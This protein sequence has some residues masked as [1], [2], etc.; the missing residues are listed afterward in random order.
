MSTARPDPRASTMYVDPDEPEYPS[1]DGRPMAESTTQFRWIVTIKEGLDALFAAYPDVFVAGD[2]LWY[3]T[4]GDKTDVMAPDAM[5]VFGR[6]KGDRRS[7]R[8]WVE[9]GVVPQVVFEVASHTNTPQEMAEK[10]RR[11]DARGVEEYYFYDPDSGE[12]E[13]WLRRPDGLRPI[14]ADGWT[15][16]RLG[17][18]FDAPRRKE[19]LVILRPDG[20]PFRTFGELA[21]DEEAARRIARAERRRRRRAE[22][23][24]LEEGERAE[25]ERLSRER[26]QRRADEESRRADA[27]ARRA[28]AERLSRQEAEARVESERL[29]RQEAEA[30]A[31]EARRRA[32]MMEARLRELGIEPG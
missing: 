31:E 6:P 3:A 18:T 27:E 11:Y 14:K 20:R 23:M 2:L 26:A 19:A 1:S 16:P 32:E 7:Y 21:K 28:D 5:V 30:R 24:A 15:S 8:E 12:L 22:R 29:S 13:G 17:V 10:R 9:D 4:K 25:S